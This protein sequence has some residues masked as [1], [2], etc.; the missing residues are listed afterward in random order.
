MD[1]ELPKW[2]QVTLV[3]VLVLIGLMM[4]ME[5]DKLHVYAI[6][7]REKSPEIQVRFDELSS[8][9]DEPAVR[10]HFD[11]VPLQCVAESGNLGDRAC[12]SAIDRADGMPAMTLVLFLSKGKLARAVVQVPWWSHGTWFMSL[13]GRYGPPQSGGTLGG[14]RGPVSRWTIL[15]GYLEMN[16]DRGYNPL[17]WSAAIWTHNVPN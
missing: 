3:V 1:Q 16:R 14:W 11:G 12:Y 15:S 17:S 6:Y 7:F 2:M 4:F 9:M 13:K 10:K 5:R 8:A